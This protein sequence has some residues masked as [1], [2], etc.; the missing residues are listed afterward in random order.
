MENDKKRRERETYRI[1]FKSIFFDYRNENMLLKT[2]W[3]KKNVKR[4]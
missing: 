2:Q 1:I 3:L 4:R